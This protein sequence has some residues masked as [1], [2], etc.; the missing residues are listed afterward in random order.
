MITKKMTL[1]HPLSHGILG[2]TPSPGYTGTI[3]ADYRD[4]IDMGKYIHAVIAAYHIDGDLGEIHASAVAALPTQTSLAGFVDT[5]ESI[6]TYAYCDIVFH[7][8]HR[9]TP[10]IL[11]TIAELG[12]DVSEMYPSHPLFHRR[13]QIITS[14]Y[15]SRQHRI[16]ADIITESA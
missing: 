9:M 6:L 14:E 8:D 13:L 15:I 10:R 2:Y 5:L 12:T 7:G 1:P 3:P 4:P 16:I 11:G